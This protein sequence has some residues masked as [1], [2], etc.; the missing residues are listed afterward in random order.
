MSTVSD[1]WRIKMKYAFRGP[2]RPR[3][4]LLLYTCLFQP[5]SRDPIF[6]TFRYD[7]RRRQKLVSE[8]DKN[9]SQSTPKMSLKCW[10]MP[11]FTR[12]WR[13]PR[14]RQISDR[15]QKSGKSGGALASPMFLLVVRSRRTAASSMSLVRASLL[16]VD[17]ARSGDTRHR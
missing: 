4:L 13:L 14:W 8:W 1:T 7:S 15:E 2:Q 11:P 3:T 6:S 17:V 5:K 10:K 16:D 9:I 12:N